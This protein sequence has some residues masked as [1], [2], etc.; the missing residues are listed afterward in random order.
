MTN[1]VLLTAFFLSIFTVIFSWN[2]VS[3]LLIGYIIVTIAYLIIP[4][5]IIWF[6]YCIIKH[7]IEE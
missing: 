2:L 7:F 3:D 5:V 1:T 6:M 4:Y